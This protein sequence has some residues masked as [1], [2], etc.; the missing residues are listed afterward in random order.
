MENSFW[1]TKPVIVSQEKDFNQILTN[2]EL[3]I[4][5]NKELSES[6]VI[7]DYSIVKS[8]I[9]DLKY[10]QI[11]NFINNNYIIG[12]SDFKLCYT[13]D[14]FKFYCKNALILEFYPKGKETIVGYIIGKKEKLNI[15]GKD[16]FSLID[17]L[18]VNFLCLTPKLRKLHIGPYMI[19][20][21]TKESISNFNIGVA[22]YTINSPIKSPYISKKQFYHRMLNIDTLIK[23]KF[24][25]KDI[26]ENSF[27]TL[28]KVYNTFDYQE[29]FDTKY[30]D[31]RVILIKSSKQIHVKSR[32]YDLYKEYAKNT[33]DIY[34]EM[35]LEELNEILD[36]KDFF[37]FL[38]L[39]GQDATIAFISFFK[40]NTNTTNGNYKNGYY[41]KMFFRNQNVI[42]DSLEFINEY[43]YK[44]NI[45][46]VLTL[47]EMFNQELILDKMIN[48]TG[49][50]KYYLYNMSS[51]KIDNH[52]NGLVTI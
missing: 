27:E 8:D 6:K 51:S 37:N 40:L 33:Y 42:K 22:H 47:P 30:N 3:L 19:N 46:D 34:E 2:E 50:L 28:K 10:K 13:L 24:I 15:K 52:K 38:I 36:N 44:N 11:V 45:F 1:K 5:I 49:N 39:D 18:E 4:K 7:L 43:I 41:Y 31:D 17:I 26:H 9:S 25:N 12:D 35:S 29:T 21:L 48:G 14:L 23:T 16:H 32:I 20:C